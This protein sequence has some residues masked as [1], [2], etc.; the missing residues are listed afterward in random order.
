MST[1]NLERTSLEAHVDLC[2]ERY[3]HLQREL[4]TLQHGQSATNQRLD[5]LEKMV[6]EIV[7]TLREK[8]HNALRSII[9]IGASIIVTLLGSLSVVLWYVITNSAG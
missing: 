7:D 6:K 1:T 5:N 4:G 3:D 8:E 2:A 9:K